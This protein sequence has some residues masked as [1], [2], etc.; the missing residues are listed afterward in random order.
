MTRTNHSKLTNFKRIFVILLTL[1]MCLSLIFAA[2]CATPTTSTKD[3]DYTYTDVDSGEIQNGSFTFGTVGTA[4]TSYP[5][6]TVTGWTKSS[7]SSAKS[8]AIDVS[9]TGWSELMT[10]LY[11][12]N[13]II[14]YVKNKKGLTDDE[15]VKQMVR[16]SLGKE[17]DYKPTTA[18]IKQFIIDN[19]LD[20]PENVDASKIPNYLF[21]N[22]KTHQGATDNK[23]YMLNNYKSSNIGIGSVQS[24]TSASEITLEKGEYA[25]VS[26]W[27]KT[28]NLNL[29][30][31]AKVNNGE[32]IGANI[33]VNSSFN[34]NKQSAFGIFNI[35]DTEWTKYTFYIQADEVYDTKFS[36]VLGLGYDDDFAEGTVYFDDVVVEL[37]DKT[38]FN[39]LSAIDDNYK[40]DYN[41]DENE[42]LIVKAGSVLD[43]NNEQDTFPLYDMSIDVS[44]ISSYSETVAFANVNNADYYGYTKYSDG[45]NGKP[46]ASSTA[47]P[48]IETVDGLPYG[49]TSA[50]K[51]N[52]TKASYTVKIDNAG[53]N[54]T[55]DSERYTALTFFVKNQLSKLCSTTV[56][57]NVYDVYG[58]ETQRRDA[59]ATF[60]DVNEEWTK[61]TVL[62][63]NNWDKDVS[64]Y[65]TRAFYLELIIGPVT[66]QDY[67]RQYATGDFY[68]TAPIVAS[69]A[70]YQ[71]ANDAD[72]ETENSTPF[73]DYYNLFS[74]TAIG[75]Q[76]LYT[77]YPE[78]YSAKETDSE[79][80]NIT[81]APSDIGTIVNN[82][83]IPNGY[84]G[85]SA[86]HYYITGD[87]DDKIIVNDN[88]KSGV[89][90]TEYVSNYDASVAT[91]LAHTDSK[92]IQPLMVYAENASYGFISNPYTIAAESY[93]LVSVN[94]RVASST[95][96]AFIYLVNTSEQEKTVME[97][98]EFTSDSG[99]TVSNKK[100]EFE[101]T[102]D[103]MGD[104]GWTTVEFY[105][106][107]GSKAK[108]FR[109][110]M[111][112]GDRNDDTATNTNN[113]YVFFNDVKIET[114]GAF[115]EP[116]R[117]QDA[118]S[119][120]NP[121]S[122]K[123][124][125][126]TEKYL[127]TQKLTALEQSYNND[128]NKKGSNV[129]YEPNYV[130]AKNETM[131][132]AIYRTIEP[133]EVNPYDSE[134]S[135][136]TTET[137][138]PDNT[139]P[140]AFWLS[141]SSIL[142]GVA[143]V[144]AI[145]ML[146]IKNIRRRRKANASDAKSHFTIVS[147]TKKQKPAK[148][149]KKDTSDDEDDEESEEVYED[150]QPVEEQT[151]DSEQEQTLDNYVYG[152]VEV[153][154]NEDDNQEDLDKKDE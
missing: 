32:S 118:N 27:V 62:I 57:L 93:A 8:G 30:E 126:L 78:D 21:T 141:L 65:T 14:S 67:V 40:I 154:G 113:G 81:V 48:T 3:D 144:L 86:N 137:N 6:T 56:T 64:A 77:G 89:I 72:K 60:S 29:T 37:L 114:N 22:P 53:A 69:G 150:E 133:T 84:T 91:A 25:S 96:K 70:T 107:T 149:A 4:Y 76:A 142:L 122:G 45:A 129:S 1:L 39:A 7:N 73:Y 135:D 131:I 100:F 54:F 146:F 85:I 139:D 63:K 44:N 82:P 121:L 79:K 109:L 41:N 102:S 38:A 97:F 47:T 117:Y 143:L 138:T 87:S 74:G 115:D 9:I 34:G 90:N 123:V 33:R 23:V 35:T 52:L 94:V 112:N 15:T 104:N 95:A 2:A 98:N 127:Y 42:N 103:M 153:F 106:A 68:I 20:M 46:D 28:A 59:V 88:N 51:V 61:Y 145:I 16:E 66:R 116:D 11:S 108:D 152:E 36:V 134:P 105:I 26:V 110:E 136:D 120:D 55:L 148:Q 12:D 151:E 24:L 130:W 50:L 132:Y 140:S 31:S 147:R 92:H 18:E 101:I 99:D 19:Y 111:W 17:S 43:S 13:G 49:I 125:D 58:S 80:Y 83:A 128:S 10:S 5:K 71:Y 124:K 119:G 75:T